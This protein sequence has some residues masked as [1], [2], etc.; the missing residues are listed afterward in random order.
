MMKVFIVY[1]ATNKMILI[2][3]NINFIILSH[4]LVL[5]VIQMKYLINYFVFVKMDM[6]E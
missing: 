6:L 4:K 5:I 3:I 2:V 1:K